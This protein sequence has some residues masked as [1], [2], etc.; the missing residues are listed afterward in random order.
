VDLLVVGG[1]GPGLEQAVQLRQARD[2]RPV[3]DLDEEL[4]ADSAEVALDFPAPLGPAGPGVDQPDAEDGA[5]A[6]QPR[7]DERAAVVAVMKSSS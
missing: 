1:L 5:A 6:Q 3:A 4:V 2:A 7:V